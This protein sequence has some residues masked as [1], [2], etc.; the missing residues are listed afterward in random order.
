[1]PL[2][3][4]GLLE[5]KWDDFKRRDQELNP[6]QETK[7]K[8]STV[9][10]MKESSEPDNH[11]YFILGVIGGLVYPAGVFFI[12]SYFNII[13]LCNLNLII[14]SHIFLTLGWSGH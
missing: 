6:K 3:R 11:L 4:K 10:K 14:Y 7:D 9:Q 1:M 12:F 8:P 2:R 5:R 13:L